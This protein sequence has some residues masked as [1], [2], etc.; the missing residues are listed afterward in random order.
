MRK[1][2]LIL[3]LSLVTGN[4]FAGNTRIRS[5]S[6]AKKILAKL[7]KPHQIT[8]YCGC[9]YTGKQVNH[10]SCGYKPKRPLTKKGKIN[11]RAYRIEWEH[12]VPAHA[13]GQSFIEWREGHPKCKTKKGKHY[14][15]RRCAGKVNKEFKRME[16]DLYNLVPAIGEVNG[17]RSNYSMAMI[18]GEKRNYGLCDVEIEGRKVEPTEGIRG[19]IARTYLYMDWSYPGR[20]VISKKNR[21]LFEAWNKLDPVDQWECERARLIE[22]QQ[23]NENPYVKVRCQ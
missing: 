8:F 17:N 9:N 23:G 13:F 10:S 15:G 21:K 16:A 2:I 22:K 19:N 20:G 6:K 18:P 11:K 7:Y 14:K 1:L 12:I 3:A 4:A 5:F